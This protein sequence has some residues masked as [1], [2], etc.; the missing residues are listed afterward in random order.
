MIKKGFNAETADDKVKV[1]VTYWAQ[2][3][4]DIHISIKLDF[5]ETSDSEL[6]L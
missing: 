1:P 2:S 4:E 5:L 6:C 3:L